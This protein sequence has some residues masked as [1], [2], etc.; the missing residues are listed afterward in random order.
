MKWLSSTRSGYQLVGLTTEEAVEAVEALLERPLAAAAAGASPPWGRCGSCRARRCCS[1]CSGAPGRCVA[2]SAGRRRLRP[3]KPCEPSVIEAQRF[4][5]WLRPVRNVDRVGEHSAVVCHCEY[6]S[7]LSASFCSV[8]MLMRP[9]IGDHAAR[10]VSSYSTIRMFGAPSGAFWASYGVQSGLESRTSSLM[11]PLNASCDG[12]TWDLQTT[13]APRLSNAHLHSL[14]RPVT[15]R[16]R[17]TRS[18]PP[19][20]PSIVNPSRRRGW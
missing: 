8:G 12:S 13:R 11:T 5:W 15:A 17:L 18:P 10:P 2:H 20:R 7:P 14:Y 16:L 19:A 4:T 9:P 3:G 6:V 1:R